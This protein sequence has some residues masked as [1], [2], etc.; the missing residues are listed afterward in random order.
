MYV[1]TGIMVTVN[2]QRRKDGLLR[3][4][5]LVLL[6]QGA[7]G[8]GAKEGGSKRRVKIREERIC[9][10]ARRAVKRKRSMKE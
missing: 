6:M 8:Q 4:S 3:L 10:D 5:L 9:K 1:S 7:R 2:N